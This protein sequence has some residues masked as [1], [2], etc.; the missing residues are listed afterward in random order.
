M[1][2]FIPTY[3]GK[4]EYFTPFLIIIIALGFALTSCYTT[5]NFETGRTIGKGSVSTTLALNTFAVATRPE[6]DSSYVPSSNYPFANIGFVYGLDNHLDI[7]LDFSGGS[8]GLKTKIM[9]TNPSSP[10]SLSMGGELFLTN[11]S[12]FHP[13][14]TSNGFQLTDHTGPINYFHSNFSLF[15]SLHT[16]KPFTIYAYPQIIVWREDISEKA[17]YSITAG[18][19][20]RVY[21]NYRTDLNVGLEYASM[22]SNVYSN[23]LLAI[24]IK[25]RVKSRKKYHRPKD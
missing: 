17:F 23:H 21:H 15:A 1:N 6:A 2:Q 18:V 24:G 22:P 11:T 4:S 25:L 12:L 16:F 3:H 9:F 5:S 20:Y 19:L 13:S 14:I 7:G 10:F 8:L